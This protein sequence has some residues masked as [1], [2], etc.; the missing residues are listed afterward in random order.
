MKREVLLH[1]LS[2][3]ILIGGLVSSIGY[4]FTVWPDKD[5]LRIGFL[6]LGIAYVLWGVWIH[7]RTGDLTK[8]IVLEYCAAA[9]LAVSLLYLIT[10]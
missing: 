3:C 10:I 6:T 8:N 5:L 9:V 4:S 1:P 7:K 2:Y